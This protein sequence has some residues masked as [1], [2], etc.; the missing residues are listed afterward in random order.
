MVFKASV[1]TDFK[2]LK[3]GLICCSKGESLALL[4]LKALYSNNFLLACK[5]YQFSLFTKESTINIL[6]YG[7][8]N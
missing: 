2:I 8:N 3:I 7:L 5:Y 4:K 1:F 6:N